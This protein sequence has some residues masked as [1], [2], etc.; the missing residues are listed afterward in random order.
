MGNEL[1][2][3]Q[4]EQ[5]SEVN[6]TQLSEDDDFVE[7]R[8]FADATAEEFVEA[9]TSLYAVADKTE[10]NFFSIA[11]TVNATFNKQT[12]EGLNQEKE[13]ISSEKQLE[14]IST[15]K[16]SDPSQAELSIALSKTISNENLPFEENSIH[17][18]PTM[19]I[20]IDQIV[21]NETIQ[22][23]SEMDDGLQLDG[24]LN[25]TNVINQEVGTTASDGFSASNSN[26]S[27]QSFKSVLPPPNAVSEGR[28]SMCSKY[29]T[30]SSSDI[31]HDSNGRMSINSLPE[32]VPQKFLTISS[33]ESKIS[34]E[35]KL[36]EISN[37]SD[38]FMDVDEYELPPEDNEEANRIESKIES[39]TSNS[40]VIDQTDAQRVDETLDETKMPISPQV[41]DV[42]ILSGKGEV[43]DSLPLES[44]IIEQNVSMN[45]SLPQRTKCMIPENSVNK[46]NDEFKSPSSS[47][48]VS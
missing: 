8:S 48:I 41:S 34:N 26:S 23:T 7:C 14:E 44:Q 28:L 39:H 11:S 38:H 20:T 25:T 4:L 27:E 16:C 29:T 10:E 32:S 6:S 2:Q 24:N 37:T 30:S 19:N 1:S 45:E 43:S 46:S 9:D 17:I 18:D 35:E 40:V 15:D 36:S 31:F 3:D 33:S 47:K 21:C 12:A 5:I 13:M 22:I 42:D